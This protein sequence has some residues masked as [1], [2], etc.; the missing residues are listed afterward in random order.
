M[1]SK[2]GALRALF[3][4]T[5]LCGVLPTTAFAKKKAPEVPATGT[6][7]DN[8]QGLTPDGHGGIARFEAFL[9]GDDGRVVQTFQHGDKLP[10]R[11]R[12]K[13]DGKHR[14]VVP[15]M[16][17][18]DA[19]VIATGIAKMTLDLTQARS[20][21][22]ALSRVQAW[23]AAHP[24]LPWIL[25]RGWD[26]NAW[27]LGHMPSAKDLDAVTGGRPAW[28]LS[29]DGQTGWANSAALREGGVSA[30]STDPVGGRIERIAGGKQPSGVLM[31]TAMAPVEAKVPRPR[32]EDIDSALGRAQLLFLAQGV[33]TVSAMGTSIEDWQAMRRAADAGRLRLRV[34]AYADNVAD[35]ALI[36]GPGP[37]PWL[38]DDRLKMNGVE[39]T[40]DGGLGSHGAWLLKPYADDAATSGLPQMNETQLGNLMSR[41]AIDNFQVAVR[42]NGDAAV[43]T[44]LDSIQELSDTYKG[45]RRWRIEGADAIDPLDVTRLG[46][47]GVT[48]AMQPGDMA[49]ERTVAEAALGAPRLNEAFAWKS[50]ATGGATL[51]FGSGTPARIP[52]PFVGMAVATSRADASGQPFGGWQP[53]EVLG[54]EAALT[55]YTSGG[56]HAL[57]ADDRLGRIAPGYRADFLFVDQ[58]PTAATPQQLRIARV[59]ETWIGGQMAWSAAQDKAAQDKVMPEDA[60]T[61]IGEG[62]K[63]KPR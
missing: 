53:Q 3:L 59:E 48:V 8:V 14:I 62:D 9:I 5:A 21:E 56:A 51:A 25:G 52:A 43:R 29:A 63:D 28:L 18:A 1:T 13:L 23:A 38:Y 2:S 61:V 36:G 55:A 30:A 40:L 20:L 37:S 27:G 45:D 54:R 17:D 44:V 10:D 39:L 41:A 46:K 19:D 31:A 7:I 58:D 33:T 34:V 24:D 16:I 42:A 32:P 57:L 11:V 22:D 6:L 49:D 47:A 4:A 26:Q 15:G 35:M 60:K 12:Y 50:V